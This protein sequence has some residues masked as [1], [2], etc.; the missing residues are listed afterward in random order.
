MLRKLSAVSLLVL[1]GCATQPNPYQVEF[2]AFIDYVNAE[3]RA[4]RVSD[5]QRN[6]LIAQKRNELLSRQARDQAA[7]DAAF[8]NAIGAAA[9][10][11][12]QSQPRTLGPTMNCTT[13]QRGPYGNIN[14]Q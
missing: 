12:Q 6:Y 4:G 1:V 2:A 13:F 9:I 3:S 5:E 10:I 8:M 14:C 7:N 11:N